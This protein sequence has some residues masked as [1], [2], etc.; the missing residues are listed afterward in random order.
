M[1]SNNEDN[2]KNEDIKTEKKGRPALIIVAAV[3]I[4]GGASPLPWS[5]WTDGRIKDFNL[6]SEIIPTS[7][8]QSTT[9]QQE[10]I[11]PA[12][13]EAINENA[14]SASNTVVE[15]AD[16]VMT[17]IQ[18]AKSSRVNGEVVIEDYTP[19]G[20]GLSRFK[21]ALSHRGE[22][23]VRVALMGDSYIE[24]DIFSANIR[25]SLQ[26][27]Y[28]GAGVGYM[29]MQSDITGFRTSISQSCSGWTEHNIKHLDNCAYKTISGEYFTSSDNA[30]TTFKGTSRFKHV[31]RWNSTKILYTSKNQGVLT[32][33]TDAGAQDHAITA[34]DNVQC[35]SINGSTS[36]LSVKSSFS[37]L[38]V[39]GAYLNNSTG[40]ALDCMSIRGNSGV[41]YRN[42]DPELAAQMREYID[43]D[44]IIIEFGINALSVQQ[45]DYTAYANIMVNVVNRVKACYPNADI[46]IMGIG[47]RGQKN[48]SELGSIPTAANMVSHQR[49]L[50]RKT[51][52]LFWDTREAMGGENA[53]IRWREQ[54]LINA[55]YVH[56]NSKGGAALSKL[57]IKSLTNI[58]K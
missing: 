6:F 26:D 58:L 50:A 22:R 29:Y 41:T 57:F 36:K 21:E 31:D 12:I 2:I 3:A 44:L 49:D 7:N 48:G 24:G 14:D 47:D 16:S 1:T 38:T 15:T 10:Q 39:L 54:G 23:V 52:T 8:D 13:A 51:G 17:V 30:Q 46:I 34:A 56:L 53:S 19:D 27:T 28:G 42:L 37:G 32:L 55:D 45:T 40:I 9:A 5:S 18:P 33:T 4:L 20:R 35:I 11:D 43:Y 25:E